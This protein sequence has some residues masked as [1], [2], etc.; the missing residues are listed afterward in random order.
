MIIHYKIAHIYQK[1]PYF[2]DSNKTA[3]S[4]APFLCIT[5]EKT[6]QLN[7]VRMLSYEEILF[8]T[9]RKC[10]LGFRW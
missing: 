2:N 9:K 1:T 8:Y 3:M 6:C 4:E 10:S 5:Q 7:Y